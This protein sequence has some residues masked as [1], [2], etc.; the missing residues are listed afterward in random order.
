VAL[1]GKRKKPADIDD[2]IA[3]RIFVEGKAH[4]VNYR[5]LCLSNTKSLQAITA[6]LIRKGLIDGQELL[7]EVKRMSAAESAQQEGEPGE[8]ESAGE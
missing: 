7:D 6:I 8:D 2:T 5:D 1:F 3:M 4:N